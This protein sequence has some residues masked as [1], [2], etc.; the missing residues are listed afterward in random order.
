MT[1][2]RRKLNE[3]LMLRVEGEWWNA[4]FGKSPA[5]AI[6]MGSI[7]MAFVTKSEDARS[8]FIKLMVEVVATEITE[9]YGER[10]TIEVQVAPK[11]EKAGSA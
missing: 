6:H 2:R 11:S 3:H 8:A 7:R 4:Y 9:A 1:A 5:D 10:P